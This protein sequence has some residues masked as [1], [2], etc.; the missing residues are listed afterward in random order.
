MILFQKPHLSDLDNSGKKQK[1]YFS[2]MFLAISR[3]IGQKLKQIVLEVECLIY[4][5][6]SDPIVKEQGRMA[7][8]SSSPT[9]MTGTLPVGE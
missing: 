9:P 1:M 6:F 8:V 4:K 3:K 5:K 2:E 7:M